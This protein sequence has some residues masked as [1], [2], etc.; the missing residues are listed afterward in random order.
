MW[1]TRIRNKNGEFYNCDIFI[2]NDNK[3]KKSANK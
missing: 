2:T 3:S 1:Y